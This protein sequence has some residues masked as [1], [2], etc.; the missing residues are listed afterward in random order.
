M[1]MMRWLLLALLTLPVLEIYLLIKLIGTLGIVTTLLLLISAALL[2]TYLLRTQGWTTWMRV[3]QSLARGEL[4]AREMIEGS[5]IA[6][7]GVLLLIPGFLSDILAL[8]CL[9]PVT[10]KMM[11]ERF[12]QGGFVWIQR[13]HPT[14]T[15]A[16]RTIEGEFKRDE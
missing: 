9:I 4:P 10:R 1:N 2:G 15:P 13:K 7:G 16:P 5:L 6:A 8:L 12:L 14:D 3:Q 11:A